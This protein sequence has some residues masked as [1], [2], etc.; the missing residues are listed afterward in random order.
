MCKTLNIKE[1]IFQSNPYATWGPSSQEVSGYHLL[2][3][4]EGFLL[5]F[6]MWPLLFFFP[7][8]FFLNTFFL[9]CLYLDSR[10]F[11]LILSSCTAEQEDCESSFV[12]SHQPAKVSSSHTCFTWQEFIFEYQIYFFEDIWN[13]IGFWFNKVIQQHTEI[14]IQAW[15]KNLGINL[16]HN[17]NLIP[18]SGLCILPFTSL[19]EWAST[20]L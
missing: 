15:Y 20:V 18:I 10:V 3:E 6:C 13:Y 16:E 12:A 19:E 14:T 5:C 7:L 17:I 1:S 11:Y 9:V 2:M 4:I 8:F